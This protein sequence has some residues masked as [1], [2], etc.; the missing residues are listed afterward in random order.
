MAA[1]RR[2]SAVRAGRAARI[3]VSLQLA[4]TIVA[5]STPPGRAGLGIVRL[6]G[7]QARGI[8]AQFLSPADGVPG[9]RTWRNFWTRRATASTR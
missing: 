2:P 1:A 8:A 5:I 3:R 7:A 6:S 9:R 4:D